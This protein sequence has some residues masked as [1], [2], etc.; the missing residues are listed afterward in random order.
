MLTKVE[1]SG[2]QLSVGD[3]IS[4]DLTEDKHYDAIVI[5]NYP[6]RNDLCNGHF[7]CKI[8]N[9]T[10]GVGGATSDTYNI[11]KR[12][13]R[14][15]SLDNCEKVSILSHAKKVSKNGNTFYRTKLNESAYSTMCVTKQK[16]YGWSDE[17]EID[18]A[19]TESLELSKRKE[20]KE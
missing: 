2:Y 13:C 9:R 6:S 12:S 18:K 11:S 16:D 1:K 14:F 8:I 5:E 17:T 3:L 10:K 20:L 15:E 19:L 7:I 4:V